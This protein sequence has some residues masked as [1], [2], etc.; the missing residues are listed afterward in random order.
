[1]NETLLRIY[2]H[3][4]AAARSLAASM[5][6]AY[7]RSWRYGPETER[8]VEEALARESWS[9]EK[10]K[11][12]QE[13][14]LAQVLHRAATRVPYYR[15]QWAQRQRQGDQA[16]W[17]HLENW[18]LL[19]KEPVRRNPR[20][21]IADDC[22][23]RKMFHTQTS[24]TTATPL[25]LWCSRRTLRAWYALFEAR[26]RRW[27]GVSRH[28][29][30]AMLGG[31][32][33]TRVRQQRPP[34]WVWNSALRQL[35]LSSYHLAPDLVADYLDALVRYRVVYLWGYT[36]A[37]FA[38]A[39]EALR[40]GRKDVRP[41]VVITNAEPV[42]DYQREVIVRAF[43]CPVRETYGMAEMAA[44]ASECEH[45]GLHLWPEAGVLEAVEDGHAAP[46][47]RAGDLICTGLV[48]VDMPLIR[49]RVG[50]RGTLP[51]EDT[52]CPCGRLLPTIQSVEGRLDDVLY[53]RDG[54][55]VGRLD[56]VFKADV[57]I[58]EAQIVQESLTRVRVRYVPA[59]GCGGD[60]A[61]IIRQRLKDRLGDM[62]VEV[63]PVACIPRGANGKFRAVVCRLS[64]EELRRVAKLQAV[65]REVE[66]GR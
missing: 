18:P 48:N 53:T 16:S 52:G 43:Q 56:P 61:Q 33:V 1:M 23:V 42:Y 11:T 50:D 22:D 13:E 2:H 14:R 36:S 46:P 9:P 34:F 40:L 29:R 4:P 60:T 45:G 19:E 32:L 39:Y 5:R 25:Q 59:V 6:G 30:W 27:Y 57:G 58:K 65:E 15:Q 66:V 12:W 38:L 17:E 26:W 20:A 47:G 55:R 54:R 41:R 44:A 7:L 21:F 37:L 51:A 63:Q 3:L 64:G 8:L 31:Q 49:Y 28:D 24:G 10:W 62:E 35:Y